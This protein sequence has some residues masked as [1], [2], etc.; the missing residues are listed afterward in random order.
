MPLRM[1]VRLHWSKM[2]TIHQVEQGSDAWLELRRDLYTGNNADKLLSFSESKKI[3]DGVVSSYA[4]N[5][6]TGFR[7]NFYTKRGHLLEDEAIEIYE[8]ITK[9]A[10]DRPGFV[11]NDR[12]PTCG[13][14]PD[15]LAP[16]PLIEIKCFTEEKH[17]KLI[18][19]NIPLKILAQI[20][21][22]MLIT[23]RPFAHL[24]PYNPKLDDKMAFKIIT[25]KTNRKIQNNFK[26][27]LQAKEVAHA[28]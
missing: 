3:I 18:D 28:Q 9:T 21:F 4:L 12:F 19:G 27:I 11:T 24:I 16:A 25:I 26:R 17:M 20:H 15:G 8:A 23:E 14:S 5:E 22:G 2:I 13:Y 10:V 6:I 1:A 7:G